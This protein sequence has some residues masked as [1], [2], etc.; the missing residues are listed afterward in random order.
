MGSAM[1]EAIVTGWAGIPAPVNCVAAVGSAGVEYPKEAGR[2][3][4]P[5]PVL[6]THK[7]FVL[8][9]VSPTSTQLEWT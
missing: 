3:I 6:G 1:L 5:C 7:H 2:K 4:V 8:D 9:A